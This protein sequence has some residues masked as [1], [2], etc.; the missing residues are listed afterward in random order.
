MY[1]YDTSFAFP[2]FDKNGDVVSVKSFDAELLIRNA[3][4]GKKYLYDIVTIKENTADAKSLL[5]REG[6]KA[7]TRAASHSGVY[8][9]NI[10]DTAE[11]SQEKI[12]HL[13]R[14]NAG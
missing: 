14:K 6:R 13:S 8:D 1:R 11:K 10:Y 7:A 4:D 5:E 2:V 9:N 12:P 3:S